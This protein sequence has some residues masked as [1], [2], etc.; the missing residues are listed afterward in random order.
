MSP[1]A[2]QKAVNIVKM[3]SWT[4]ALDFRYQ[5][6]TSQFKV[7]CDQVAAQKR[8]Q[9]YTPKPWESL[10]YLAKEDLGKI[11]VRGFLH[12]RVAQNRDGSFSHPAS[13]STTE[14]IDRLYPIW[15]GHSQANRRTQITHHRLVFSFSNEFHDALVAAGRNPDMVLKGMVERSMRALQEKFHPGDSIGYTYGVHHDTDNL[16]AHVFIH[17]R[18]RSGKLVGMSGKP[19]RH[20]GHAS[21]HKDQLGFLRHSVRHR[22]SGVLKE[23][24]DPKEAAYLKHHLQSEKIYFV[25]RRSHTANYGYDFQSRTPA[26][27]ELEQKRV[28]VVSL[29]R[30]I[31]EAKQTLRNAA[32]G[33]HLAALLFPRK[34]KWLRLMQNAQTVALF[35]QMRELQERRYRSVIDYRAT[36]RHLFGPTA[37]RSVRHSMHRGVSATQGVAASPTQAVQRR[38]PR[39]TV[40]VQPAQRKG[41]GF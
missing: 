13:L 17:P 36:Q 23:I 18:T 22:V 14:T 2:V 33:S 10:P 39:A 24:S 21:R 3:G 15:Q 4:S 9:V 6:E 16:H 40:S 12:E 8:N 20:K 27:Y 26:D 32:E 37:T 35:R 31:G 11:H 7:K 29:D 41:R 1:I 34:P 38:S 30:K 5:D 25:P 28:A 19:Q